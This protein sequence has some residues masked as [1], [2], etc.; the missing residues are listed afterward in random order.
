MRGEASGWVIAILGLIV[1]FY[2]ASWRRSARSVRMGHSTIA[3]TLGRY[4]HGIRGNE[5]DTAYRR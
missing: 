3:M 2:G 5:Q 4:T 1:A